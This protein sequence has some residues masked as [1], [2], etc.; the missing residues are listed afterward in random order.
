MSAK[1]VLHP[2]D[3]E[4]ILT[5]ARKALKQ[6]GL[7]I[8]DGFTMKFIDDFEEKEIIE[9]NKYGFWSEK[10]HACIQRNHIY[11]DTLNTLEQYL[12][13]TEEDIECYNIWNQVF[14][15]ESIVSEIKNAG[16]ENIDLYD[17]VA[18]KSYSGKDKTI[19]V[20]AGK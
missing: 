8:L 17:D 1:S 15:K 7:L 10:E 9:Y 20:V 18:G 14:T 4:V 16:F 3:R 2:K 19:C 11:Q 13:I 6:G 5:K 12:V